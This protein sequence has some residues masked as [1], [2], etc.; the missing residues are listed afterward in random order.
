MEGDA[1]K[2]LQ[3]WFSSQCDGDWEHNFGFT[4]ETIDNP[5]WSLEVDLNNTEFDG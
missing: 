4:I 2:Q 1:L 5:G 3:N